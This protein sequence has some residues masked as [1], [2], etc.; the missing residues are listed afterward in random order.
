MGNDLSIIVK[1]LQMEDIIYNI[2]EKQT[3]KVIDICEMLN[4]AERQCGSEA[5]DI[6]GGYG[7]FSS[8]IK[9]LCGKGIIAPVKSS[10][11]NGRNPSLHNKYKILSGKEVSL[12]NELM[13]ELQSLH[14]KLDKGYYYRNPKCYNEDRCYILMLS[15]YLIGNSAAESLKYRCTMNE[16]S[17]EIFNNEKFLG[18]EGKVILKRLGLSLQDINCYKTLEAFF[19]IRFGIEESL[20]ILIIENKDSFYSVLK[21]LERNQ[22]KVIGG[23]KINMLIYG[24]GK[25]IVNSFSFIN[26]VA[27]GTPIEKVYYFGDLDFEGIGIFNSMACKYGKHLVVPHVALY[28]ELLTVSKE[29]PKLRTRQNELYMELFLMYFD[30]ESKDRIEEILYMGKYI[31][32]EALIFGRYKGL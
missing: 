32:Q 15:D 13:N 4:E 19:Y 9:K 12:S 28:K 23:V 21:Y 29:P 20:N 22:D 17:F 26:E 31:P 6:K 8:V 14:P 25:K 7:S 11:S 30:S 5:F 24:E 1:D 18:A 2:I 16:R 27:M 10:G 3:K